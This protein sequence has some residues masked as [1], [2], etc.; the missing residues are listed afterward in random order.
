MPACT[1]ADSTD[2][3]TADPTDSTSSSSPASNDSDSDII[4]AIDQSDILNQPEGGGTLALVGERCI[5]LLDP[6]GT[7][8]LGLFPAGTV[9]AEAGDTVTVTLPDGSNADVGDDV[10][11]GGSLVSQDDLSVA[12][13]ADLP[14]ECN[15]D[16]AVQ[17]GHIGPA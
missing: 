14:P 5:G 8:R 9:V 6:D 16:T 11:T 10:I 7:L 13:P 17:I 3:A 2:P 4:V 15:T 12:V 1:D